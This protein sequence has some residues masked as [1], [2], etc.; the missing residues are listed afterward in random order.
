MT[1]E[2]KSSGLSEL[3]GGAAL[4]RCDSR[5]FLEGGFSR[6]GGL[7]LGGVSAGAKNQTSWAKALLY[8]IDHTAALKA[9]RHP[10]APHRKSHSRSNP[11][12]HEESHE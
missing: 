6:W 3:L 8:N 9:L 5:L 12:S 11:Q 1:S 4:K 10:K 7:E 2:L